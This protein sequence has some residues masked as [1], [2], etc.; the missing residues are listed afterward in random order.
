M[1]L[2]VHAKISHCLNLAP[3]AKAYTSES[4]PLI[5]PKQDLSPR[6]GAK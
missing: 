4:V 6:L 3:R 2:V 5:F 1:A